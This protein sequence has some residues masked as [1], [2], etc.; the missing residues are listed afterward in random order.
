M[1]DRRFVRSKTGRM[2][3]GVCAGLGE[4]SRIDPLIVRIIFVSLALVNGVGMMAYLLLWFLI[5]EEDADYPSQEE[6]IKGNAR[7]IGERLQSLAQQA[8]EAI[9][10][11]GAN[12]WR[13]QTKSQTALIG[14]AILG[15]GLLIL[16]NN[17]GVLHWLRFGILWP[18]L[19][20]GLGVAMLVST[21][22]SRR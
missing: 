7:E 12:L 19:L 21:L 3:G 11:R 4:Y 20:I 5:P 2:L 6:M 1:K 15:L 18:V 8:G 16:L 9:S 14:L 22:R 17:S 13:G 10:G